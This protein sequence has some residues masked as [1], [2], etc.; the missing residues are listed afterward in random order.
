MRI[1]AMVVVAMVMA[2]AVVMVVAVVVARSATARS[3]LNSPLA[4]FLSRDSPQA[5]ARHH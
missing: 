3:T 1:L 4:C 2:V 5:E